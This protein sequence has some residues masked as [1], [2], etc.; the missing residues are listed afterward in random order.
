MKNKTFTGLTRTWALLQSVVPFLF[1]LLTLYLLFF[2]HFSESIFP[3]Q[4]NSLSEAKDVFTSKGEY[5]HLQDQTLHY[6]G[7]DYVVED[8]IAGSYYYAFEKDICYFFLLKH[9]TSQKYSAT[10]RVPVLSCRFVQNKDAYHELTSHLAEDLSWSVDDVETIV[11]PFIISE[12]HYL[13][14]QKGLACV[15]LFICIFTSGIT[16][17]RYLVVFCLPYLHFQQKKRLR[18]SALKKLVQECEQ[19]ADN[20]STFREDTIGISAD[21]FFSTSEHLPAIIPMEQ[22]LWVYRHSTVHRFTFMPAKLTDTLHVMT[23]S[24]KHYYFKSFARESTSKVLHYLED[25][26]PDIVIGYSQKKQTQVRVLLRRYKRT[27]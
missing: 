2:S 20:A 23:K 24:G 6:T 10:L 17:L 11:P 16:F 22:L 14:I 8:K 3:P 1:F 26:Y 19:H 18:Y 27:H 12:C 4:V 13:S 21:M 9:N 25:H 7:Y 15:L 5:V